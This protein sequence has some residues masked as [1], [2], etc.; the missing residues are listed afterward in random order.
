MLRISTLIPALCVLG[1]SALNPPSAAAQTPTAQQQVQDKKQE[2]LRASLALRA[3]APC[4]NL[5]E[6][7]EWKVAARRL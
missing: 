6:D 2:I 5:V 3:V 1:A 7:W 4:P